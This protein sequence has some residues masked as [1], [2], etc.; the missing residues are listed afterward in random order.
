MAFR[1]DLHAQVTA[2][3]RDPA[4]VLVLPAL[5]VTLGGTEAEAQARARHHVV[6][7]L[8]RQGRFR[9]EYPG[10]TLRD[11]LGLQRPAVRTSQ[12]R[13]APYATV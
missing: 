12:A 13:S 10:H 7:I 3:G 5:M 11:H 9:T 4:Q 8:Q 2:A 1:A 6:P